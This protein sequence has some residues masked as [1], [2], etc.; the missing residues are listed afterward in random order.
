MARILLLT[1]EYDLRVPMT[2]IGNNNTNNSNSIVGTSTSE[3]KS[4]NG[5]SDATSFMDIISMLSIDPKTNMDTAGQLEGLTS[6]TEAVV[7]T[8]D[9]GFLENFLDNGGLPS[10]AYLQFSDE[11]ANPLAANFLKMLQEKISYDVKGVNLKGEMSKTAGLPVEKILLKLAL[12]EVADLSQTLENFPELNATNLSSFDNS[13]SEPIK[14]ASAN[15]LQIANHMI[16]RTVMADTSPTTV[17]LDFDNIIQNAP[18][19][20]D[21]FHVTKIFTSSKKDDVSDHGEPIL[22]NLNISL[23]PGFVE[24]NFRSEKVLLLALV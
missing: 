23:R 3:T 14:F 6:D 2:I 12:D 22:S 15:E 8:H 21:G 7:S 20:F 16:N 5:L 11:K 24:A 1:G 19:Y 10:Q 4:P 17:I 13:A 18:N 9:L